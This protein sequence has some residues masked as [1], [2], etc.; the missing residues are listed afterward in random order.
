M[1][2]R[3]PKIYNSREIQPAIR[4]NFSLKPKTVEQGSDGKQAAMLR[5]FGQETSD[6]P[7]TM[8]IALEPMQEA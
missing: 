1:N 8:T 5:T 3:P 2:C 4:R 6:T 7:D